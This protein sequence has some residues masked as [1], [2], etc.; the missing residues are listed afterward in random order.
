MAESHAIEAWRSWNARQ[1]VRAAPRQAE[2]PLR[3]R[4]IDRPRS[5]RD[6]DAG[7]PSWRGRHS[8]AS[9]LLAMAGIFGVCHFDDRPASAA[10]A[11][12]D[13]VRRRL[14]DSRRFDQRVPRVPAH[15]RRVILM[16][17]LA[18]RATRS[19]VSISRAICSVI[20][21]SPCRRARAARRA[22][23]RRHGHPPAVLP[24]HPDVAAVR[25]GN[26]NADRRSR[27]P[28]ATEQP[29]ARGAAAETLAP[30]RRQM[31]RHLFAGVSPG[32]AGS[33]RRL[34]RRRRESPSLLGFR[35][36]PA[37][38]HA[39]VRRVCRGISRAI[40]SGR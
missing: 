20:L 32:A 40:S 33:R 5:A 6:I 13:R 24:A 7:T 38:G 4:A 10:P 34:H 17:S 39:I 2:S 35:L 19:S 12:R 16:P 18:A 26:Q 15:L 23:P 37:R 3:R 31:T 8:A 1:R 25:V 11:A 36:P 21:R 22:R 27:F 28:P 14:D 29:A 9:I 30:P